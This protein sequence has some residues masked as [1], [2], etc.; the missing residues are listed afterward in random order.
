MAAVM[1]HHG[2]VRDGGIDR[3]GKG[4]PDDLEHRLLVPHPDRL[5]PDRDDYDALIVRHRQAMVDGQ[6]GYVDPATGYVV[7]T[8][9]T[10]LEQGECCA[11][12]CRHCPW[13]RRPP[14]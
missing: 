10:L 3:W 1:G 9:R 6:T 5:D 4:L 14:R 8:A 12:G 2:A 7:L 11:N 13:V